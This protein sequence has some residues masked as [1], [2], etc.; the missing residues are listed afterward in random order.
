M[1]PRDAQKALREL[2]EGYPVIGITG[3][4]QSGKTTLAQQTF[5]DKPYVSLE[6]PDTR[7]RAQ[8][9]PRG[10]LETYA[11]GAI[12]DEALSCSPICRAWS[13]RILGLAVSS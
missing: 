5:A 8:T 2:A 1:I 6:D 9:D 4:R 10:F 3:P 7:D 12:F 13:I 11:E